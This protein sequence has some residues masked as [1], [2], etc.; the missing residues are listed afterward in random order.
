MKQ[1]VRPKILHGVPTK[2]WWMVLYPER[3]SLGEFTDIGAFTLI[4]AEAGVTIGDHAQIGSHCS[5]Y[6]VDSEGGISGEIWIGEHVKIG[7]HC[8]ILP[9][10][11]IGAGAVI[12][13]HS[14]VNFSVPA[15]ALAYGVPARVVRMDY[16]S[17]IE[18]KNG[19]SGRWLRFAGVYD[20]NEDGRG[21]GG[22]DT[23]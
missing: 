20:C 14:F 8:S 2:Y 3:L 18:G 10:V 21:R 17:D 7:S 5:L 12:G 13:A 15:F 4:Q 16:A 11:T 6:S 19:G 22:C 1:W 9:G 23:G